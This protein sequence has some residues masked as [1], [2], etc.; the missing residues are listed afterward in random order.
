M[1]AAAGDD[2]QAAV[3]LALVLPLLAL[4]LL[5]MVQVGLV[6]RDQVLLTHAAREA[7]REAAVDPSPDASRRA[8]LAGAPLEAARLKLQLTTEP[9][10]GRV[11]ARLDYRSPTMV[12]VIG[13]L[14]PEVEL[15][16]RASM[17][18]EDTTSADSARYG[19]ASVP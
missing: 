16:A 4:L 9:E 5:G 3:E 10:A 13:P 14:L 15:T 6:V 8:A 1:R 11:N 18:L 19:S 2:G 12:P 17:R 7:V